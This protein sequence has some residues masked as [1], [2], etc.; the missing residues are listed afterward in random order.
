MR[1]ANA[2]IVALLVSCGQQPSGTKT[3]YFIEE[4]DFSDTDTGKDPDKK[5]PTKKGDDATADPK[6]LSLT[7][8]DPTVGDSGKVVIEVEIKNADADATWA[9]FY[10]LKEDQSDPVTIDE[11][12][13]ASQKSV[14]WDT[15]SLDAGSYYLFAELT[16]GSETKKFSAKSPVVI[17]ETG[18][19][20]NRKPTLTLDFPTGEN[21]FV[22]GQPQNIRWTST[23]PDNDEISFKVE[24]SGDGGTTWTMVADNLTAKQY[25]WDVNGLAQGITYK[26]KV[27]AKDAKGAENIAASG[28]NFG[29]ATTAM[30]FAA[31]YGTYLNGANGISGRCGSCHAAGRPNAGNFRTDQN[32]QDNIADIEARVVTQANMPPGGSNANDKMMYTLWKWSGGQ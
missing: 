19:P 18:T 7:M 22:A 11:S 27:T 28:K 21:V 10:S 6:A 2:T 3:E 23:D 32:V 16:N 13:P 1:M 31:G 17:D 4:G 25:A 12:L 30:T 14:E 15:S 29:V 24:Y 8:K 5:E 26:V 9:A 20:A